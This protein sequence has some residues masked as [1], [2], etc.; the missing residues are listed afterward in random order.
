MD[1]GYI[2]NK[3]NSIEN[4][5]LIDIDKIPFFQIL[6]DKN[7]ILDR[8]TRWCIIYGIYIPDSSFLS[9]YGNHKEWVEI[10]NLRILNVAQSS[11]VLFRKQRNNYFVEDKSSKGEVIRLNGLYLTL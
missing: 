2:L 10:I 3:E 1:V 9:T 8:S 4:V 7:Y 6:M 5:F 11:D